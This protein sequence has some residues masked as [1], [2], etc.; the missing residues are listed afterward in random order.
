[1]AGTL[2]VTDVEPLGVDPGAIHDAPVHVF[3]R[4]TYDASFCCAEP[5]PLAQSVGVDAF[6]LATASSQTAHAIPVRRG[7]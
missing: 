3:V 7:P 6:E 4:V 5:L 2:F 1:M